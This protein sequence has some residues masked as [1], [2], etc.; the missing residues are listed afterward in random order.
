VH[1]HMH[2]H[3]YKGRVQAHRGGFS[4]TRV[5]SRTQGVDFRT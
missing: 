1:T 2:T 5:D 3:I 4:H